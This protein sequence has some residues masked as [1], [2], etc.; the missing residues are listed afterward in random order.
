M[1]DV[2]GCPPWW[3]WYVFIALP[4]TA[5]SFEEELWQALS[6]LSHAAIMKPDQTEEHVYEDL[7][8]VPTDRKGK[9]GLVV[10]VYVPPGSCTPGDPKGRKKV[11]RLA[12]QNLDALVKQQDPPARLMANVNHNY[13]FSDKQDKSD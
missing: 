9:Y 11:E 2:S 5:G 8:S 10:T 7:K 13:D 1:Y 12:L 3:V 6:I 4:G